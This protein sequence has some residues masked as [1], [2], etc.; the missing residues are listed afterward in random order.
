MADGKPVRMS[1]W[2][3]YIKL[4]TMALNKDDGAAALIKKIRKKFPGEQLPG[5]IIVFHLSEEDMRL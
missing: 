3:A 4:Y 1:R 2:D 5:E